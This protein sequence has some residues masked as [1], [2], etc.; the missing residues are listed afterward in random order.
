MTVIF[1]SRHDLSP[2]QI[3]AIKTLHGEDVMFSKQAI[4]F[5][6]DPA[7]LTSLLKSLD[8]DTF[9]YV[10]APAPHLLRAQWEGCR[11]GLF[12]NHPAKRADGTFG[13]DRVYHVED[14]PEEVYRCPDPLSDQGATMTPE[15]LE[16]AARESGQTDL[17][18]PEQIE[19]PCQPPRWLPVLVVLVMLGCLWI[20]WQVVMAIVSE[21]IRIQEHMRPNP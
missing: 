14:F 5:E 1:L 20:G 8:D 18:G 9:A 4:Q 21:Y 13:L 12:T 3:V 16:R 10:V 7:S 15:E 2:A 17:S 6:A 19:D 11:F